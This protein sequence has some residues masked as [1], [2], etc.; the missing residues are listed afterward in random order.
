MNTA[1][2]SPF[3]SLHG[4]KVIDLSRMLGGPYCMQILTDHGTDVLKIEPPQ[5]DETRG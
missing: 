1:T 5:G 2:G 3:G 4:I